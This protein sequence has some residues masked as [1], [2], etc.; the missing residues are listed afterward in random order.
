[1][2]RSQNIKPNQRRSSHIGV[3]NLPGVKL[4]RNRSNRRGKA[5]LW[6]DALTLDGVERMEESGEWKKGTLLCMHK[7]YEKF[8]PQSKTIGVKLAVSKMKRQ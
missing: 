3:S 2:G 7:G 8:Q 6:E 4:Y 5:C 1:M